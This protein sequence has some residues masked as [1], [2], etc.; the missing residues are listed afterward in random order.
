MHEKFGCI[1]TV[2][3][4]PIVVGDPLVNELKALSERCAKAVDERFTIHDF[5]MTKGETKINLIFDLLIPTDCKT[6]IND[7]EK[8]VA[9]KIKAENPDCSCVIKAEHPFV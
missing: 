2:H 8:A 3:L 7:A 9:D 5:R 4:D 1:V 6:P